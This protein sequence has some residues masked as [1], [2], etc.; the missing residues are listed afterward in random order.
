MIGSFIIVLFCCNKRFGWGWDNLLAEANTGRGLKVKNWMKPL[1]TY[2]IPAVIIVLY[3]VGL[4][5][6]NWG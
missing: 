4:I 6:Y 2:I 5:N 1:F 3:I